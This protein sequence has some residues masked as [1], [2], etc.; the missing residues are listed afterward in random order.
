V[1][2]DDDKFEEEVADDDVDVDDGCVG[3]CDEEDLTT[4]LAAAVASA[5]LRCWSARANTLANQTRISSQ[6]LPLIVC[7]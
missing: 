5:A 3:E 6:L 2:E 7:F 1:A 4:T